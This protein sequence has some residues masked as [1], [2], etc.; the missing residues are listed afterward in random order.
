MPSVTPVPGRML[1]DDQ[2]P[3]GLAERATLATAPASLGRIRLFS[4]DGQTPLPPRTA[5]RHDTKRQKSPEERLS[6]ILLSA[7]DAF[8]KGA[9]NGAGALRHRLEV[10][11]CPVASRRR[12]PSSGQYN[13]DA[14][15]QSDHDDCRARLS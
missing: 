6:E 7:A 15:V 3:A 10:K 5:Y 1:R 9:V 4:G 13:S 14:V 2:L 8:P 11:T 12:G